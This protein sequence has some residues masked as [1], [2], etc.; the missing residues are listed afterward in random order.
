MGDGSDGWG[1]AGKLDIIKH[2]DAATVSAW[3]FG[4][5]VRGWQEVDGDREKFAIQTMIFATHAF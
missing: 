1:I 5:H 2:L 4:L 3:T